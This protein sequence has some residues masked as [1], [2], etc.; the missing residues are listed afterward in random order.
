MGNL[1]ANSK[2]LVLLYFLEPD[3]SSA[4]GKECKDLQD[5]VGPNQLMLKSF[6]KPAT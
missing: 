1:S 3:L 5:V 4:N 6:K 2:D